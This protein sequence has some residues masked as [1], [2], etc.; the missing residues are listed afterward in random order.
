[1]YG[2]KTDVDVIEVVISH[3]VISDPSSIDGRSYESKGDL[4]NFI[5]GCISRSHDE[6]RVLEFMR[7]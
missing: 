6:D 1:M 2:G 4:Y 5:P 7:P 3:I